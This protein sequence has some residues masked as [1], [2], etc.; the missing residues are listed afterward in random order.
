MKQN[1][2][3]KKMKALSR[4]ILCEELQKMNL[5]LFKPR[6]DQCDL[7]VGYDEGNVDEDIYLAQRQKKERAQQEKAADKEMVQNNDKTKVITV[8]LQ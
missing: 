1:C 7:C 6:K 4:P 2:K 3:E 8:D 5:S